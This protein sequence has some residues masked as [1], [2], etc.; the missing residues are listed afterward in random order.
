MKA[1][2]IFHTPAAPGRSVAENEVEGMTLARM[3]VSKDADSQYVLQT[4]LVRIQAA[5][6]EAL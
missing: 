2:V 1:L 6:L 4:A 3:G 5:S